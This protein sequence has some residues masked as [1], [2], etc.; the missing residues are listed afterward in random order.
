MPYLQP[1]VTFSL[2]TKQN[3]DG[4]TQFSQVQYAIKARWKKAYSLNNADWFF[5]NL[6]IQ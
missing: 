2:V 5:L 3:L 6:S 4:I 1:E